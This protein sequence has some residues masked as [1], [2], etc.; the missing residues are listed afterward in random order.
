MS[1]DVNQQSANERADQLQADRD[2]QADID[3]RV[4]DGTL[5]PLGNGRVR[6][7]DPASWDNGEVLHLQNGTLIPQHGLDTTTGQAAL[8]SAVPA[9]HNLGNVIPGGTTDIDQV[10][11]LGGISYDVQKRIVR[12]AWDGNVRAMDDRWVTVRDDT[13]A[14]LGTVGERYQVIQKF[15]GAVTAAR[16]AEHGLRVLILERGAWR[17][18]GSAIAPAPVSG[19]SQLP[20]GVHWSG[21]S[22]SASVTFRR[23]GHLRAAATF[24]NDSAPRHQCAT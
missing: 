17:E 15:G 23:S 3:R 18:S 1:T 6:I 10:L 20:R 5:V 9:W 2:R 24:N 13:G 7:N 22:R 8:Y 11:D 19:P 4:A 16:L 14:P 21:G 12:Y